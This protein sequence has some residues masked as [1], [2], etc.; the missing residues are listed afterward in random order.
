MSYQLFTMRTDETDA[1]SGV[2][3]CI[4]VRDAA[5][6]AAAEA[7]QFAFKTAVETA[8]DIYDCVV[9]DA[10]AY[11]AATAKTAADVYR[12]ALA[13]AIGNK[14]LSPE[15]A[16]AAVVTANQAV[17][18]AA[19]AVAS[20]AHD[21]ELRKVHAAVNAKYMADQVYAVADDAYVAAIKKADQDFA[22]CI[23]RKS[24]VI[25]AWNC[26][27]RGLYPSADYLKSGSRRA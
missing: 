14:A 22:E 11:K 3:A 8:K 16:T 9:A 25:A 19:K 15:V 12:A 10:A 21:F 23:K 1:P 20:K 4:V 2:A 26:G 27:G 7:R 13:A 5:Y 17:A 6:A 24:Q 18:A